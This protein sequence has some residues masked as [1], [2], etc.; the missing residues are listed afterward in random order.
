MKTC[1]IHAL[2]T[3]LLD[4][5]PSVV[6][7][8]QTDSC[9]FVWPSDNTR[10]KFNTISHNLTVGTCF[11]WK[12]MHYAHAIPHMGLSSHQQHPTW[13]YACL[14]ILATTYP[15]TC[16]I[17]KIWLEWMRNIHAKAGAG[18]KSCNLDPPFVSN[19][20]PDHYTNFHGHLTILAANS[21][22]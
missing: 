11:T 9:Q 12:C 1:A 18:R 7:D 4:Q 5:Y 13:C 6:G 14:T 17:A 3:W 20:Q 19:M 8:I 22:P 21:T 15:I 2:N 10:Y 16:K